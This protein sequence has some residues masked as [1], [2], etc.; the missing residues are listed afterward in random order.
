MGLLRQF[1]IGTRLSAVFG[2]LVALLIGL[3]ALGI[4]QGQ[5]AHFYTND[6]ATNWLPSVKVLG[7]IRNEFTAVRRYSLNHVLASTP[8]EKKEYH[9]QI[10]EI[11]D[12]HVPALLKEY[13]PMIATP[14]ER[15]AYEKD[16]ELW[17]VYKELLAK[18]Y[19][20]SDAGEGS[21]N[22]ARQ[23]ANGPIKNDFTDLMTAVNRSIDINLEGA[24]N[25]TKESEISFTRTIWISVGVIIFAVILGILLSIVTTRSIVRPLA[26]SVVIAE[27]VAHGDLTSD[28]HVEGKDEPAELLLSLKHMNDRLVEVVT[29]VRNSSDSIATGSAEIATGNADLS[30][31]TEAQASNLQQTA[32]SMEQL[33]STVK[34]NADTAQQANR[35]AT[36]ASHAAEKGGEVVGQVVKTMQ[37]ISAA[38][39]KISDII[40]TIDGI[41]FQTNILA[42]NAAVEAAR[43]GEQGRGFAVVASEVRSLA[44]RSAEAAKEIKS[45]IGGSVEKV[46]AGTQLVDEAGHSMIE[47]VE[48]V[49][50][51]GLLINE[52][53]NASHEQSSGIAQVGDAVNQLDQV[54]QQNA[55]L[56]EESAAAAAS[57]RSQAAA[58][59]EVVATFKLAGHLPARSKGALG[60]ARALPA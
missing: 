27:A 47:I 35:L 12:K 55:A 28:I 5:Q 48:Q 50:R 51:V 19:A 41:A 17:A 59:A 53:S 39:N 42:L 8:Q 21:L 57:L 11:I 2:L 20:L 10:Q 32:A 9:D 4:Y 30:Q 56:V 33:T 26:E 6:L 22:E 58:L 60:Y 3:G 23:F 24:A 54:T 46:E 49:K 16:M 14:E 37:E 25:S 15:K 1:K 40:G 7:E 18:Q 52:I 38:S 44:Q 13:E 34:T 45:L 31:R 43:A 29:Q 36:D